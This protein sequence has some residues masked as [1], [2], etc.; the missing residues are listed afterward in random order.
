MV[1]FITAIA[2]AFSSFTFPQVYASIYVTQ[3]SVNFEQT[4]FRESIEGLSQLF[5]LRIDIFSDNKKFPQ[6]RFSFHL[7]KATFEQSIKEI[8]RKAKI[9]N[10]ALFYNQ[11]NKT[12]LVW[13]LSSQQTGSTSIK[14]RKNMLSENES[15]PLT[16]NQMVLL[17][18]SIQGPAKSA[19]KPLSPEQMN[20]L[21]QQHLEIEEETDEF[22]E[23][24]TKDQIDQLQEEGLCTE[25]ETEENQDPL[26]VIEMEQLGEHPGEIE[27]ENGNKLQ[28]LSREQMF[29]LK[30][31]EQ[32]D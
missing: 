26:S 7:E 5:D 22:V 19:D 15:E 14:A 25:G 2:I 23:P 18:Q 28:P 20:Q 30:Q 27:S 12:A 4:T 24:L 21:Q 32:V 31:Q 11:D 17:A 9:Q 6:E 3:V 1:K 16:F 29:L 13:I 8:F 10:H